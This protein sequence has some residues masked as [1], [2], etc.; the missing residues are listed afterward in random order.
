MNESENTTYQNLWDTA[1]EVLRGKFITLNVYIRKEEVS[2]QWL[3]LLYQE[4]TKRENNKPK[5]RGEEINI[6]TEINEIFKWKTI[7]KINET[8]VYS[9]KRSIQ[10]RNF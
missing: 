9:L 2:N 1:T 7:K 4:S 10:S 5:A 8:K 3:K 6:R